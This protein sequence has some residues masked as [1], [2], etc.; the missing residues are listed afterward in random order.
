MGVNESVRNDR[1]RWREQAFCS[2]DRWVE[3][4][5]KAFKAEFDYGIHQLRILVQ[6]G[7]SAYG[8]VIEIPP[9][10]IQHWRGLIHRMLKMARRDLAKRSTPWRE[11]WC[12]S[13]GMD[14][15]DDGTWQMAT[16]AWFKGGQWSA[17]LPWRPGGLPW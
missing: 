14:P 3:K 11:T 8:V 12:L 10:V 9:D 13:R 17:Q 7:D 4:P 16:R 6:R 5:R 1:R 2:L 15:N